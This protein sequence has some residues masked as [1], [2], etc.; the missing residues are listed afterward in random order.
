M[1]FE[2]TSDDRTDDEAHARSELYGSHLRSGHVTP[3]GPDH[4]P[5]SDAPAVTSSRGA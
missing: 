4:P 3:L 2:P 1:T 5:T